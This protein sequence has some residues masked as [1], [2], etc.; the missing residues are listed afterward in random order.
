MRV[1]FTISTG[2]DTDTVWNYAG[3]ENSSAKG[4]AK[5]GGANELKIS[6]IAK[7]SGPSSIE[8]STPG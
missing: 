3:F 5:D 1:S 6:S 2:Q 8:T 7:E 4:S